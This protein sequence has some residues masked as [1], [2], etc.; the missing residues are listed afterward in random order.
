M[1]THKFRTFIAIEIPADICLQ[2][3]KLQLDLKAENIN[4][5]W[6]KT[7]NLHLTL[8]F[9]GDVAVEQVRMIEDR[10]LV[11]L[12]QF[13]C[14]DLSLKGMGVFP[15]VTRPRILWCGIAGQIDALKGLHR[16]VETATNLLG[17]SAEKRPFKGHLTVGRIK[18]RIPSRQLADVLQKRQDF[19]S[20][21]FKVNEIILF[22]SD[23]KP[24]G[25]TYTKLIEIP[26][27]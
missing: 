6:V 3:K 22:K 25:P 1:Q 5:R 4:L 9:L 8:K 10:L 26:L 2:I 13:G 12:S 27:A 19:I 24:G 16:C 11:E 20:E 15:S 21:L 23:L 7:E 18:K 14:F 17:I